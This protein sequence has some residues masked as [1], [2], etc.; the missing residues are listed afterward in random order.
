M[1][2]RY[3]RVSTSEQNLDAS[4]LKKPARRLDRSATAA[5]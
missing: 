2:N 5:S 1:P 4:S 3:T